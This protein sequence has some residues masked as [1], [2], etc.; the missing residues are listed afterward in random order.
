VELHLHAAELVGVD[1]LTRRSHHRGRL[2]HV[3][4]HP[5]G[6]RRAIGDLAR[7]RAEEI[8]VDDAA[9]GRRR[10]HL[11]N[12]VA[13]LLFAERRRARCLVHR[14]RAG[15]DDGVVLAVVL[16]LLERGV[17]RPRSS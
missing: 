6:T 5:R 3:A 11:A 2:G 7:H 4:H 9:G 8:L 13:Q 17:R 10:Q 16:V 12:G 15:L 1:V 14:A